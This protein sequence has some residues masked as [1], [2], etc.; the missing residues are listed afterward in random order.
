MTDKR[1]WFRAPLTRNLIP[2]ADPLRVVGRAA[3][4]QVRLIHKFAEVIDG[5]D[6]RCHSVGDLIDVPPHD[7]ALLIAEGWA[8]PTPSPFR[9][10]AA[11]RRYAE[12]PQPH[13]GRCACATYSALG[14]L[15]K[16][17]SGG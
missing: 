11:H 5:I 12:A 10:T 14:P 9:G 16:R 1:R 3:G 4:M 2:D 8:V 17:A 13:L 15:A 6:L 7:A